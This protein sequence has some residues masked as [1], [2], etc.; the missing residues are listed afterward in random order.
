MSLED[1]FGHR[2]TQSGAIVSG[3]AGILAAEI[4]FE[5]AFQILGRYADALIRGAETGL[6]SFH[7]Q[8]DRDVSARVRISA[9][10][11]AQYKQNLPEPLFVAANPHRI[12]WS[13]QGNRN[14]AFFSH[15][16]KILNSAG[17]QFG[18]IK[19]FTFKLQV[20][21]FGAGQIQ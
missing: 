13:I 14:R 15:Y 1:G 10:I 3:T 8:G 19:A 5:N 16:L 12:R 9:G 2:Q 6:I 18:Q 7:P 21:S 17:N 4:T 11:V 20:N